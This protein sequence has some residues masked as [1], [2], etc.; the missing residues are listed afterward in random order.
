M[1]N[2]NQPCPLCDS[3]TVNERVLVYPKPKGG[4]RLGRSARRP[5]VVLSVMIVEVAGPATLTVCVDVSVGR[6]A[7]E[8]L[9]LSGR[10]IR[11]NDLVESPVP[12]VNRDQI[13]KIFVHFLSPLGSLCTSIARK[14]G[15]GQFHCVRKIFILIIQS[16]PMKKM[17]IY[18][19]YP[20]C[21]K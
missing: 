9:G 5:H 17:T 18:P 15:E 1:S 20:H 3:L 16:S 14:V 4:S 11:P 21:D 8:S 2:S 13:G 12:A 7:P 6:N 19:H 10:T